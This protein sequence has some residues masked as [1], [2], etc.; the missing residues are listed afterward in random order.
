LHRIVDLD[1]GESRQVRLHDGGMVQV[2]VLGL[3]ESRD[4]IRDAVRR[5]LVKVDV[6]GQVIELTSATYHLPRIVGGV[7]VDCPITR[8][9]LTNTDQ[10]HWGL[11]KA[12]RLR[13]W[14]AGSPWVEAATFVYPVRQRWFA[15]ATQMANEPTFVDGVEQP[16]RRRIYYHGGLDIGGAEGLVDVLAATAGLVVSAGE[17]RLPG[18]EGTPIDPRYDVIYLLDDRGWY[19]RYSHLQSFDPAIKPGTTVAMGQKIGVLGKEGGSG[20]WSHLHFEIVARQPSGRWG[21]EEGY[22]FLWQ[23][24]LQEQRPE[25]VAV[26]RPHHLV[27]TGERVTLDGSLSWSRSGAIARYDWA[28]SDGTAAT[29]TRVERAYDQSGEYSEILKVTDDRGNVSYDFA[30]VQV[31]DPQEPGPLSPGIHAAYAPTQGLHPGDPITFKVRTFGTTEGSETWDFGDGTPPVEVRSDGNVQALARGGYAIVT[32]RFARPGDYLPRVE[33]T[34][35]RGRKATARLFVRIESA[36]EEESCRCHTR[37]GRHPVSASH[38]RAGS[39][40]TTR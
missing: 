2:K 9:Y 1:I 15:S 6:N 34:D 11:T 17:S 33:R 19:Y 24:T 10:D 30:V 13:L 26:A 12:V 39:G 27:K 3:E 31:L 29:A 22:A 5:A 20:G 4:P 35:R 38:G 14:P 8:G 28:F 37:V 25:V 16:S 7:Q 23:A 32:H 18:Y 36:N 21:T 40:N